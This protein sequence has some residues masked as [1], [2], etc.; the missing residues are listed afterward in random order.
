MSPLKFVMPKKFFYYVIKTETKPKNNA[1][2]YHLPPCWVSL[3]TPGQIKGAY[4]EN[5]FVPIGMPYLVKSGSCEWDPYMRK[6]GS[7]IK[8]VQCRKVEGK[9]HCCD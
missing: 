3:C 6:Q 5:I 1:S 7:N 4:R 8:G 2:S 9:K